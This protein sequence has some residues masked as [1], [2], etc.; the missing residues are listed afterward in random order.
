MKYS[1]NHLVPVELI[2]PITQ[3]Q[4]WLTKG[5]KEFCDYY[6]IRIRNFLIFKYNAR[7]HF[8]VTICDQ[9]QEIE[10]EEYIPFNFQTNANVIEQEVSQSCYT[11]LMFVADPEVGEANSRSEEVGPK[12]NSRHNFV[13]LNGDSLY[14]EITIPIIFAPRTNIDNMKNIW[15]FNEEGIEWGVEI[16]YNG[17]MVIIKRGWSEF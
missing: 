16:E 7:A 3:G 1:Q 2:S 11:Y 12:N 14:F 8:D 15:L 4:I 5:W 6:S 10:I 13:N 17:H 9:N